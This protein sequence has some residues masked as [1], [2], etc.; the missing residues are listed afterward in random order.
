M[1][2]DT[3]TEIDYP[4]VDKDDVLATLTTVTH[5][6]LRS[7]IQVIGYRKTSYGQ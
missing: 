4:T 6:N 1:A 5:D 3:N 7:S 2:D